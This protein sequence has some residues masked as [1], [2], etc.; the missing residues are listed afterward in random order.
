MINNRRGAITDAIYVPAF[1]TI[2]VA[3]IFIGVY[4][5]AA[6]SSGIVDVVADTPQNKTVVDAVNQ[7]GIGISSFDYMLP[8][9]V[10]G[11]LIV[12]LIFAF[13]TGASV[14][15]AVVSIIMWA[16]AMLMAA[17]YTD[18]FEAFS[19]SFPATATSLPII[20]FIMTNM[21]WIVLAWLFLLSIVMFSRNKT[22]DQQLASTERVF[23]GA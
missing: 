2:L 12:S 1:I 17:V 18:I 10:V 14:V 13:K 19:T 23:A 21:R 8:I 6:F 16:F 3:T 7:I 22:E 11:L 15:Y 5:W 4:V 20:T 9:I